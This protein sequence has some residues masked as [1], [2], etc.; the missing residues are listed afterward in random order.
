MMRKRRYVSI[1]LDEEH[2]VRWELGFQVLG[3]Q[4]GR[5]MAIHDIEEWPE[6]VHVEGLAWGWELVFA[7]PE[8]WP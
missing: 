3:I 1:T 4:I 8:Q 7:W 2:V 5:L 6:L